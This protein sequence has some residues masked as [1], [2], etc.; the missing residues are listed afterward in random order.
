MTSKNSL[1]FGVDPDY[2]T[3]DLGLKLQVTAALVEVCAF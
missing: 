1:A 3:L 2:V